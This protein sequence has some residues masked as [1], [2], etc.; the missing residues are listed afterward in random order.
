M[1]LLSVVYLIKVYEGYFK[2]EGIAYGKYYLILSSVGFESITREIELTEGA[3]KFAEPFVM[4]QKGH[5]LD[6]VVVTAKDLAAG[7]VVNIKLIAV[8]KRYYDYFRKLLNASGSDS[9]P[10]STTPTSVNGNISNSTNSANAPLGY[11]RLSEVDAKD[12]TIQ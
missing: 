4:Q 1:N 11:F 8:S 12:Y 10:F 6:E 2:F 9:G 3:F 7:D 5:H